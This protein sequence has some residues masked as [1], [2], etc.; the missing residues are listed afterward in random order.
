MGFLV[1][2]F[3]TPV[4]N[5]R[6]QKKYDDAAYLKHQK[7]ACAGPFCVRSRSAPSNPLE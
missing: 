1:Y 4:C 7:E 6:D 3:Q 5:V 2:D